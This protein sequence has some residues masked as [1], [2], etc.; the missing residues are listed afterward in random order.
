MLKD[1]ADVVT[2]DDGSDAYAVVNEEDGDD[3]DE[4]DKSSIYDSEGEEE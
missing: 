2:D 1:S 4:S 3:G